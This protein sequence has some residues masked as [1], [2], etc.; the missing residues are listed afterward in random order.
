MPVRDAASALFCLP[1]H[2]ATLSGE[3]ADDTYWR[4]TEANPENCACLWG[5]TGSTCTTGPVAKSADDAK[6]TYVGRGLREEYR[7]S[8]RD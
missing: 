6:A 3:P 4:G 2:L 5:Q 8:W 7:Q 1:E